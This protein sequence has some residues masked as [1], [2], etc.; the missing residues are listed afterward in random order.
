MTGIFLRYIDIQRIVNMHRDGYIYAYM[1]YSG[2]MTDV[3]DEE[4]YIYVYQMNNA[5]IDSLLSH[6]EWSTG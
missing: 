1:G 2:K 3:R 4:K 5:L 6:T